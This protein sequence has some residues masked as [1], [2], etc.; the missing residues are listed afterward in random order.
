MTARFYCALLAVTCLSIAVAYDELNF[1]K[2]LDK[3]GY[4]AESVNYGTWKANMEFV[5]SHNQ[6]HASFDVTLNKFA[7]LVRLYYNVTLCI[8]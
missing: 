7:H 3:Y 8:N 6:R 5:V 2:W 1:D 4:A